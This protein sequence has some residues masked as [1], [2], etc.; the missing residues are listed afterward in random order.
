M[1]PDPGEARCLI[2][3]Q[4]LGS[5]IRLDPLTEVDTALEMINLEKDPMPC[6]ALKSHHQLV[7][8]GEK[9][10]S[11]LKRDMRAGGLPFPLSVQMGSHRCSP[12]VFWRKRKSCDNLNR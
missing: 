12:M 8:A 4:S 5:E 1:A 11:K 3:K 6:P 9:V 2:L 10:K 7:C